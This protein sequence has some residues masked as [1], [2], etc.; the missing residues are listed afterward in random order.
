M[1]DRYQS[2]TVILERDTRDD[3]CEK[4]IKAIEQMR[5]VLEV[6]GNVSDLGYYT[7]EARVRHELSRKLWEVLHPESKEKR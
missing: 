1:T 3:D 4:L 5:G 2:L 7:A 6:T